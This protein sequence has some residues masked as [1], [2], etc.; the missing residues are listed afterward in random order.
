M[1]NHFSVHLA[2]LSNSKCEYTT[3]TVNLAI[4]FVYWFELLIPNQF[5]LNLHRYFCTLK[6]KRV[7]KHILEKILIFWKKYFFV[8]FGKLYTKQ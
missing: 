2:N 5:L 7:L 8:Q 3:I 1:F 4:N 6:K